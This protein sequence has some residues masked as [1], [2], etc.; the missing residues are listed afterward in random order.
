VDVSPGCV[1][2]CDGSHEWAAAPALDRAGPH[3][4]HHKHRLPDAQPW[5]LLLLP[6]WFG[7]LALFQLSYVAGT[8]IRLWWGD[9]TEEHS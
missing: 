3:Q 4:P 8:A 7:V 1:S 9:E 6:K 5:D 2:D